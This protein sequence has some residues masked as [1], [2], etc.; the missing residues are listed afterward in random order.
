MRKVLIAA[1]IL[2]AASQA[3]AGEK[4]L[5]FQ[6][7]PYAGGWF[8]D[9]YLSQA[10]MAGGRLGFAFNEVIGLEAG[11]EWS[12]QQFR[13]DLI[14]LSGDVDAS[15]YHAD[16]LI[17]FAGARKLT[18]YA[19]IG[20]GDL[21]LD[22]KD[23]HNPPDQAVIMWGLGLKYYMTEM[24]GLRLE[25]RQL[26]IE[27]DYPLN[28][29]VTAGLQ[30]RFGGHWPA[31]KVVEA[32]PRVVDS[33]GD[34]VPDDRDRCP[35]TPQGVTVND[36]GCPVDTDGDTVPDGIDSCPNTPAGAKVDAK[37][38]P[39]D[40]DGDTVPDGIDKCPNTPVGGKVN[41]MG[42]GL[43]ADGDTIPDGID[44]CPNTPAGAKID[45][46]G[47][48][49]KI[50]EA[51]AADSDGDT[52]LD[53]IDKCPHTPKGTAVD[54]M[55]CAQL[56][57][58]TTLKGIK[59]KTAKAIIDPSSYAILDSV[60]EALKA[61]PE[62]KVEIQGYTD[63]TGKAASNMKLSQARAMAVQAYLVK[64]G[65]APKRLS[66]KG[67]GPANPVAPNTT[68][69]GRAENRRIEFKVLE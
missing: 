23:Y 30:M 22:P 14:N 66:A 57:E 46:R 6:V 20:G 15:L 53:D 67:Y 27:D 62:M 39:L 3:Y 41:A 63:N 9:E 4:P 40:H 24:I 64:K 25:A 48:P 32:A 11:F 8:G 26:F 1:A 50:E 56:A 38:C 54:A 2:L 19:L 34:T 47:C 58:R 18:P 45:E 69:Q 52:V 37:G 5:S 16:L 44:K 60:V 43:D 29:A 10:W 55:G 12:P 42:C 13:D 36:L 7:F 61:H 17:H 21:I 33:D 59:F 51:V 49:V 35:G 31:Q 68:E 28:I 65:I